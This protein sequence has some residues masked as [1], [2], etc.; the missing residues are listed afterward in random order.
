MASRATRNSILES[1]PVIEFGK[2]SRE[3]EIVRLA[4]D[5]VVLRPGI[6]AEY[7]YFPT[8]SVISFVGETGEGGSIE[9]WSVGSEGAA[10]VS[11]I[12]GQSAPFP[13]VVQ[14]PGDAFRAKTSELKRHY[15]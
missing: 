7:L 9:V 4:R 12:L 8:T 6:R 2:I 13:G 1:L 5:V 10:G 11:G 14:I 15:A 3:L